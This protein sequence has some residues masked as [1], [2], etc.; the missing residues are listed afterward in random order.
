MAI[1][2]D[3]ATTPLIKDHGILME[4]RAQFVTPQSS[5]GG[6]LR[7]I[8]VYAQR[9]SNDRAPLWRRITQAEFTADHVIM[10]GDF[11]HLEETDRR[12]FSGERQMHRREVAA[13]HHMTMH[14]GLAD[15]WRLDSFWKMSK[16]EF[17]Y[18]NG[19]S[20]ARSAVSRIDKFIV[21]QDIEERGGR[22]EA[23]A[24]IRKLSDHSPLIITVWGHHP[25]PTHSASLT[26]PC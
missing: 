21:S 16:K 22:M 25:Q 15:T 26:P 4:G 17:T 9:S 5:E 6:T 13:W 19:R 1:L 20:G 24:S 3:K 2:V 7:I 11:N 8:N 12:G 10:G 18:D 14:Y 23:A